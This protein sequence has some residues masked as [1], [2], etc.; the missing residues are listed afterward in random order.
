MKGINE[1]YCIN[2]ELTTLA[3]IGHQS[4]IIEVHPDFINLNETLQE[5][6]VIQLNFLIKYKDNF[7][8]S[9]VE[10]F[11]ETMKRHPKE[12]PFFLGDAIFHT[13]PSTAL[14]TRR[15]LLLKQFIQEHYS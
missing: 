11:Q 5:F 4:G 8:R 10:A 7:T 2:P 6:I 1:N 14:N 15:V 3:R 12:N 13:L 9:D